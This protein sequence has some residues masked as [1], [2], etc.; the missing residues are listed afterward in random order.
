[1][2]ILLSC[3]RAVYKAE[4]T[5]THCPNAPQETLPLIVQ[6]GF[7]YVSYRF[8]KKQGNVL[9]DFSLV[10]I[11]FR[12]RVG[13]VLLAEID[14]F[15]TDDILGEILDS[16][17]HPSGLRCILG[18]ISEKAAVVITNVLSK[19]KKGLRCLLSVTIR[20][21]V[22]ENIS[23]DEATVQALRKKILKE[24]SIRCIMER[25]HVYVGRSIP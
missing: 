21:C 24:S 22:A 19:A 23:F 2:S 12:L 25:V 10:F 4:Y 9:F 5:T 16:V 17:M 14:F 11:L 15:G 13:F 20:M 7:T 8:K 1:V 18:N 6:N 3:Y